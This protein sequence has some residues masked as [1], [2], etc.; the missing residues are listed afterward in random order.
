MDGRMDSRVRRGLGFLGRYGYAAGASLYLFTLGV[1]RPRNRYLVAGIADHFGYGA[2]RRGRIPAVAL[3]SLVNDA[4]PFVLREAHPVDGNVSLFELVAICKL[5]RGQGPLRLFEIGTFDGRTTLNMA[6]NA[7]PGGRVFTL[8][9]PR[10]ALGSTGLAVHPSERVFIEKPASGARFLG[11]D[12][13]PRITQL[14]GDSASFD[15][16]PYRR[17]IDVVFV[18]GSHAYEYVLADTR[19]ALGLLRE[20]GGLVLWHDYGVWEGVTQALEELHARD[21]A[22]A[23]LRQIEGSSLVVL[24]TGAA[25]GGADA[26]SSGAGGELLR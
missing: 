4:E 16:S 8:D 19:T 25:V 7:Q 23:G 20:E 14:F 17:G 21:P 26:A 11:T 9:L 10:E 15:F 22:F 24:R 5:V 12:C 2:R 1:L 6:A 13:E 3:D 18:D